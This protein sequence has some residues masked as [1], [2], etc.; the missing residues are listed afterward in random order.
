MQNTNISDILDI[1]IITYNRASKLD[2]TLRQI[3]SEKSPIKDFEITIL[4]N[5]STDNTKAIVEKYSALNKNIC[6]QK[7]KYNIGGNANIVKAFYNASKEYVWVLADND[8]YN[9]ESWSEVEKAIFDKKDAIMVSTYEIPKLDIAQFFIQTTFV[10]GVIYKTALIDNEVIG[11]M[12]YNISNMFP[13]LSLSAKLINEKKD[14]YIVNNAIVNAGDNTDE[15]TGEYIYTRGYRRSCI[16]KLMEELNWMAG[17]AN[18]LYLISDKKIRN[19]VATHN[20]FYMPKLNSAEVFFLNA[21]LSNG[22][23]YNLLSIFGVLNSRTKIQFLF[24]WLF[25]YTLFRVVYIYSRT[26]RPDDNGYIYKQYRVRIFNLIK[27]KLFKVKIKI[28]KG[29]V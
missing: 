20:L 5:N 14:T 24:N 10:P 4:D 29:V 9:W 28:N 15:E 25:Y 26:T 16:H 27:T 19:Y 13:Q 2:C 1:F 11:N 7:N 12:A 22:S 17:Y 8:L 21:K 3:L 23:L 18:S 6:Y